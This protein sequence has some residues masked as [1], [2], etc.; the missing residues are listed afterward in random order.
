MVTSGVAR[1]RSSKLTNL[2]VLGSLWVHG[3]L[4]DMITSIFSYLGLQAISGA[5]FLIFYY[6]YVVEKSEFGYTTYGGGNFWQKNNFT[7]M[8]VM[9]WS[10]P[11]QFGGAH[12]DSILQAQH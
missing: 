5:D 3:A 8:S 9:L 10:S 7:H 1:T 2:V 12:G 4:G 6:C 11:V